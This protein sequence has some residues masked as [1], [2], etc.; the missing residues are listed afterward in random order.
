MPNKIHHRHRQL[1]L[2]ELV[3]PPM[4]PC[5]RHS[6]SS[7]SDKPV[8]RG[9]IQFRRTAGSSYAT[10]NT[11]VWR[12]FTFRTTFSKRVVW[13]VTYLERQDLQELV[14]RA[15]LS[16]APP[17]IKKSTSKEVAD[18]LHLLDLSFKDQWHSVK[19]VLVSLLWWWFV[20]RG[21]WFEG[22]L[23]T[24]LRYFYFNWAFSFFDPKFCSRMPRTLTTS[25]TTRQAHGA[26]CA[27]QVTARKNNAYDS[28]AAGSVF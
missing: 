6:S 8:G 28:K 7:N 12:Y 3:M 19:D 24:S 21:T 23:C 26:R 22:C 5:F 15:P 10:Y 18:R 13:S 20:F 27:G 14:K 9:S 1:N 11:L 4:I 25:T 16:V 2:H 17:S